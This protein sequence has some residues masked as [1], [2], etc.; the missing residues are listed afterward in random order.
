[1]NQSTKN[2]IKQFS[3]AFLIMVE[4]NTTKKSKEEQESRE[5]SKRTWTEKEKEGYLK[6]GRADNPLSKVRIY[7]LFAFPLAKVLAKT[8]ITANQITLLGLFTNL[9]VGAALAFATYPFLLLAVL[10]L[11]LGIFFDFL[12]GSLA[13]LKKASSIFGAWFD[14]MA[15]QFVFL[16]LF[17]GLPLGVSLFPPEFYTPLLFSYGIDIRI[18]VW[19]LSVVSLFNFLSIMMIKASYVKM[20]RNKSEQFKLSGHDKK[21]IMNYFYIH[22][23]FLIS[24]FCIGFLVNQAFLF[25]VIFTV[26]SSLYI[27]ALLIFYTMKLK[28]VDKKNLTQRSN[29]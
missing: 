9:A 6:T 3:N 17:L 24:F 11:Q 18:F 28:A 2:N 8:P 15:Q 22:K 19:I 4:E 21:S 25:L 12:D 23:P 16:G 1:M 14:G 7:R 13:R 26:Y 5:E 27:V 29:D 10:L 20:R